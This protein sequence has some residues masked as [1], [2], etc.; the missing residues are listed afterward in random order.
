MLKHE[1]SI[2]LNRPTHVDENNGCLKWKQEKQFDILRMHSHAR[3]LD[4]DGDIKL[5]A[6]LLRLEVMRL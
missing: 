2:L 6:R 3:L 1:I 5:T 4:M